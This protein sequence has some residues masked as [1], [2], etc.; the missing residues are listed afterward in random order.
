MIFAVIK[1]LIAKLSDVFGRGEMYPFFLTLFVVALILCAKSPT[2]SGYAAGYIM[3]SIAQSGVN[4]MNDILVTDVSSARQ[5]G[6][7]VQIQFFPYLF[8]P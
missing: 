8:M 1:P 3:H 6:L 7:A 2:Y 4:T 5:R